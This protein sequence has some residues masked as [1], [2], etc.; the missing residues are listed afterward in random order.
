MTQPSD[1]PPGA[2]FHNTA[3]E[4]AYVGV[5]G[6][7]NGDVNTYV[8]DPGASR[9]EK[10]EKAKNLLAAKMASPA[11]SS[12]KDLVAGGWK[13]NEVVY[14]W[15]LA[16]LSERPLGELGTERK[17]LASAFSLADQ[18][19]A[20]TWSDAIK[21][22]RTLVRCR[23]DQERNGA[24][25]AEHLE[26]VLH[27]YDQLKQERKDEIQI[28][29]DLIMTGAIQ[30]RLESEHHRRVRERRL[31]GGRER[32]VWK[33]F[34]PVPEPPRPLPVE[35][36]VQ[37]AFQV[38]FTVWG[39]MAMTIGLLPTF[40]ISMRQSPPMTSAVLVLLCLG[41]GLIAY[42]APRIRPM[43]YLPFRR[44]PRIVPTPGFN[45]SIDET[46]EA[47]FDRQG[48]RAGAE[49]ISWTAQTRALG[50][51]LKEELVAT[52]QTPRI[53]PGAIDWLIRWHAGEAHRQWKAGDLRDPGAFSLSVAG[54]AGGATSLC[55]GVL[56]L[57]SG[58]TLYGIKWA[59]LFVVMVGA[60][61]A[62]LAAGQVDVYFVRRRRFSA[63]QAAARL[64]LGAERKEY[65]R[66]AAELADRPSD[67]EMARWLEDDKSYLATMIR[68][69]YGLA[70]TDLVAQAVLPAPGPLHRRARVRNGPWRYTVY[71]VWLFLLTE[72]GMRTVAIRLDFATGVASDQSR[73]AF[74]YDAI[75]SAGVEENGVRL[76]NG[77][78]VPLITGGR[79]SHQ[80][81]GPALILSQ[82]LRIE[83][84]SG[85][86]FQIT[87][88]NFQEDDW[89]EEGDLW[90][91][92]WLALDSSGV[93]NALRVLEEVAA[94]G[95]EKVARLRRHERLPS[96]S[97]VSD[98]D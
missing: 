98:A 30:D 72:A 92:A 19:G 79:P 62:L 33:Y 75:A 40:Y 41:L 3:Q 73:H 43:R 76:D 25:D 35:K 94:E 50:R 77:R 38:V 65:L 56:L 11:R 18:E 31:L 27:E 90:F 42:C 96:F 54:F 67:V 51:F 12:L 17:D 44:A 57:L 24:M 86:P 1:V 74:R 39:A 45:A 36:P 26:R 29:L 20:D 49:Q 87:L 10:L 71:T 60:G 59:F 16:I 93:N 46:V 32:R 34:E 53:A 6:V 28:H 52:Y 9:E 21:V 15:I 91:R 22:I 83:L 37:S 69:Q 80:G 88:Q 78:R 58:L 61:S 66:W 95:R 23:E 82:S 85:R 48:E 4:H 89:Q 63:E 68:N 55:F 70:N 7:V 2:T 14:Y 8:V 81:P 13:T 97:D 47:L 5:Q 64:R 84:V